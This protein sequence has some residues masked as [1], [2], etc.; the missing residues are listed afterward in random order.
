MLIVEMYYIK[1]RPHLTKLSHC[2]E[3][4]TGFQARTRE[5]LDGDRELR[6]VDMIGNSTDQSV[7][8]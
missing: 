2:L 6:S 5:V 1:T 7:F 8:P 4:Y 3:K